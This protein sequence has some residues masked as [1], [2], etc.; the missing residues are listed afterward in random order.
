[1]LGLPFECFEPQTTASQV[2]DV[3]ALHPQVGIETEMPAS[4][5][6][7]GSAR[8]PLELITFRVVGIFCLRVSGVPLDRY[9]CVCLCV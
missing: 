7:R 6:E 4:A 1:M 2:L 9:I 8:F 5:Q 3:H